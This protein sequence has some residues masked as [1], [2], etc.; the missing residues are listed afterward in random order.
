M[1][2]LMGNHF[3]MDIACKQGVR[4]LSRDEESRSTL[5]SKHKFSRQSAIEAVK[6]KDGDQ[7]AIDFL[8]VIRHLIDRWL[9][10]DEVLCCQ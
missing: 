9:A 3:S 8:H 6:D 10:Q 1:E 5:I 2:F 7:E 4:Y